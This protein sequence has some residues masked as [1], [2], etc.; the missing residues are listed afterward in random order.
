MSTE[1]LVN[2]LNNQLNREVSTFLRYMLQAASIK[3]AEYESVRE[4]YLEEVLDEVK[5]AQYLANQIEMLG[6]SPKLN[7]DLS[8]PPEDVNEML[9][10]DSE[11]EKKDVQ[12]YK[13]L[14]AMAEDEELLS[15]KMNMEDQGAEED[16]HGQEMRRLLG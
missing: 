9:R 1:N 10:N 8:S 2:A 6:G 16:E 7:P 15:L 11:E 14:A 13:R 3:G 4:M 5:H 12:N